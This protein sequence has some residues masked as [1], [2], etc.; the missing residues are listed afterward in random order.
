MLMLRSLNVSRAARLKPAH[1]DAP[2]FKVNDLS[3]RWIHT[4]KPILKAVRPDTLVV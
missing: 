4:E 1:V 2:G 3:L